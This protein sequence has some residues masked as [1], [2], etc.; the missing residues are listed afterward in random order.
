MFVPE[1]TPLAAM[2]AIAV[3]LYLLIKTHVLW[4]FI[5]EQQRVSLGQG[6]GW[7]LAWPG[8][9]ASD[10]F[11]VE[12]RNAPRLAEL[13]VVVCQIIVG[14]ALL[15]KFVPALLEPRPLIAAIATLVGIACLL[16]FAFFRV[17][18]M[19]C[20]AMGR[21]VQP[22][23]QAPLLA[24]SVADFWG[25]RWNTAFRDYAHQTV[26]RPLAR[27]HGA[28]IAMQV[29]FLFSGLIHE[30]AISLPAGGGFG[31]PMIYFIL[32]GLALHLER[33]TWKSWLQVSELRRRVWTCGWVLGWSPLLF[34]LPFLR[35]V[36]QPL[37]QLI[38][39]SN[40]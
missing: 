17:L 24:D 30:L 19:C 20:N 39:S 4:M 33:T 38:V 15:G 2:S 6:I 1:V 37:A 7:Y 3:S 40:L 34:H 22:I 29:G 13:I 10:F 28:A 12:N 27:R 11:S 8:M 5:S 35:E 25:R 9:N 18:A 14:I 31:L 26:F 21:S 32:Q 23:M 16:H 36:V